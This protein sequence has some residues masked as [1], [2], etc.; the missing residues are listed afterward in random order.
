MVVS[1][2]T[3][4]NSRLVARGVA[5]LMLCYIVLSVQVC[6]WKTPVFVQ[7]GYSFFK[8]LS[9]RHTLGACCLPH[10]YVVALCGCY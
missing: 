4:L 8:K 1:L 6:S 7:S 5:S 10:M 9:I 3:I 2:Y